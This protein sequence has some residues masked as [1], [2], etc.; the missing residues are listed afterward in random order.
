MSIFHLNKKQTERLF[1]RLNSKDI[2]I[3]GIVNHLDKASVKTHSGFSPTRV[4]VSESRV[5]LTPNTLVRYKHTYLD[6][7]QPIWGNIVFQYGDKTYAQLPEH[8]KLTDAQADQ[9]TFSSPYP[10]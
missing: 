5:G 2:W 6:P 8:L 1:N 9:I 4:Y 7:D 3:E 10:T